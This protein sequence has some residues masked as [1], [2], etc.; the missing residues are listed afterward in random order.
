MPR[1]PNKVCGVKA[2]KEISRSMYCEEHKDYGAER[3]ALF[4]KSRPNSNQ[5]GYNW[6]WRKAS[7]NYLA[8]HPLCVDCRAAGHTVLAEVVDH[9]KPH[10]GDKVLFWDVNNWQGLC[11]S[12][13]N[14]KTGKGL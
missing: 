8:D 6:S 9:I 7:K 11:Y 5:R 10:R 13:H 3:K 14:I 2:C 1:R 12:H 4:D